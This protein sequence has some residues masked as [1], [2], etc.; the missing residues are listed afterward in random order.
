MAHNIIFTAITPSAGREYW[1]TDGTSAGT[2]TLGDLAPGS[3]GQ[4][5]RGVLGVVNKRA[6]FVAKNASSGVEIWATGGSAA[7]TVL[8]GE[9]NPGA[10]SSMP[11]LV[12]V[13]GGQLFFS[14]TNAAGD[15]E[16][17]VTNGWNYS[18]VQNI[19]TTGSSSPGFGVKIGN[20]IVFS[21][22]TANG[23]E[24][25]SMNSEGG[26]IALV[27]DMNPG[28]ANGNVQV[29]GKVGGRALFTANDG[30]NVGALFSTDGTS[31][32]TLKFNNFLIT[33]GSAVEF[34]GRLIFGGQNQTG[35]SELWSTDG[36][37]AGTVR[38]K[39]IYTGTSGS[40]PNDFVVY[41][42][43]VYFS[44]SDSTNG[45][46]LWVTD[47]T[48]GGT[49]RAADISVGIGSSNPSQLT[50]IN[51][52]IVFVANISGTPRLY[53][54][55]GTE[56][57]TFGLS[58][59]ATSPSRLTVAGNLVYFSAISSSGDE[60]W[61]TDG[62]QAGTRIVRDIVPGS[63]S[64][65]A[66]I[67][68]V[69]NDQAPILG[70]SLG[71]ILNGLNS[72]DQMFG[73][74]GND[75]L[76][77][78]NGNDGLNGGEGRD[79]LN[80]GQGNDTLSGGNDTFQDIL[81]GGAGNDVYNLGAFNDLP[82]DPANSGID[83]ALTLAGLSLVG[84]GDNIEK[85]TLMGTQNIN[86]TGNGLANTIQGNSGRNVLNGGPDN[87]VDTLSGGAGNDTYILNGQ[88]DT[89]IENSGGGSDTIQSTTSRSLAPTNLQH[90]EN[91]RLDGSGNITGTGNAA[92]NSIFGNTGANRLDGGGGNDILDGGSGNDTLVGGGGNDTLYGRAGNDV[93][94]F[95][96][97][98]AANNVDRIM[99]YD[100]VADRIHLENAIFTALTTA[101]NLSAAAFVANATGVATSSSH[102]IVYNTT[103]GNLFYDT[104]GSTGGGAV[105]IG[106]ISGSPDTLNAGDFL[107]I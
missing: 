63:G 68:A 41:R 30:I 34:G 76:N 5:V 3:A 84:F 91:L 62:T 18:L 69:I 83:T 106:T 8:L 44:A 13:S 59:N 26:G 98:L 58:F 48:P 14:A 102:R 21:A 33:S 72:N 12:A 77:A 31:A 75:T 36:T 81:N 71:E 35:D 37:P 101:G 39:D 32:G 43:K 38:L 107:V 1:V 60:L 100:L 104:N 11:D 24:L 73:G 87:A 64:S 86:G 10:G 29:I 4:D 89:V 2:V 7:T 70:T 23:R 47:G 50:V 53:V 57:G 90:V 19:N 65:S 79:T 46:E 67:W 6:I 45:R 61:V 27:K 66:E 56:A 25:W 103:N 105:L 40:D 20:A 99:D 88:N 16:L 49:Q 92:A 28:T 51:D 96:A 93:Y 55:D 52:R 78:L 94:L 85:L 97:A 17:Y 22:T 82:Q 80:G 15:R 42:G 54:T 9:I 95:N 74:A